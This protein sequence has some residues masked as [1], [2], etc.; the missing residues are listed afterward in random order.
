MARSPNVFPLRQ[1]GAV[2][3]L[4]EG[5]DAGM[6]LLEARNTLLRP[7]GGCK[8]P[9][10]YDRL[11][12]IGSAQTVQAIYRAL[13]YTG[14]L[15]G[16][17]ADS[18]ARAAN[19]TC[20]ILIKRQGKNFLLFYSLTAPEAQACKGWFYLG[21]DDSYT[22]GAY[23]FT[24]GT[25]TYE[26][27]AV[28]LDPNAR[29]YGTR[30]F[31][32]MLL[33]NGV[34]DNVIVQIARTATPGKWRKAGSNAKPAAPTISLIQP[35]TSTNVQASWAVTGRAG[36]VV[37]TFTADATNFPGAAGN[38]KIRVRIVPG[39]ASLVSSLAGEGTTASP[40]YYTLNTGTAAIHSS[41]NAIVSYV[42]ADSRVLSILRASTASSNDAADTGSY[43]PTDL[44][45]GSGS[46]SSEGFTNSTRK[47]YA[48][49]WDPGTEGLGYEGISSD[50][51][52]EVIITAN[53]NNDL[54]VR[55]PVNPSA[56]GGRFPFIRLYM[57]VGESPNEE[58]LLVDPDAPV[59]NTSASCLV[60][61]PGAAT[62][63]DVFRDVLY[64]YTRRIN[65]T[66]NVTTNVLTSVGHGFTA[67]QRVYLNTAPQ[68]AGSLP[69]TTSG[70]PAIRSF[71]VCNPTANTFQLQANSISPVVDFTSAGTSVVVYELITAPFAVGDIVRFTGSSLPSGLVANTDYFVT[72]V[73]ET[74]GFTAFTV[75]ATAAGSSPAIGNT[76]LGVTAAISARGKVIG[77]NTPILS[78]AEGGAM[79]ADQNRPLPH[80]YHALVGTKLWRGGVT[81]Y[82]TRLY[83]SKA[84]ARDELVP[85]GTNLD[86][87]EEVQLNDTDPGSQDITAMHTD[88]TKL[89]LH[90]SGGLK[91][92]NTPNTDPTSQSDPPVLAGALNGNCL[93]PWEKNQLFYLGSDLRI[94]R[95]ADDN[96]YTKL[97][98]TSVDDATQQY[99]RDRV[100]LT[101]LGRN[102]HR[103]VMFA[104][105]TAKM[106]WYYL[107][108]K[109]GT[110]K[111]FVYDFLRE[112]ITGEFDFPKVYNLA[113]ME[114]SRPELVFSDEAGNLF[115]W[116]TSAQNDSGNAFPA[117]AAPTPHPTTD[118]IPVQYR[119]YGYVDYDHDG[120]GTPSRFYQA[121]D[122][123]IQT[124]FFDM[125]TPERRKA[126]QALTFRTVRN[127]RGFVEATLIG[128]GGDEVTFTYGDVGE[129]PRA[130]HRADLLLTD[131]AIAVRFRVVAAEQK[132][133]I[134][135]DIAA[136]WRGQGV[137]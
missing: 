50:A 114:S 93:A 125:G 22:S 104:D 99:L 54:F 110:L 5:T 20:A 123:I 25:P 134:L 131:S 71:V 91:I 97:S 17:G 121:S 46:G 52:N 13:P 7:P 116:D 48:R 128:L 24:A 89:H 3:S 87:F 65:V 111:G 32:A 126:L 106:L 36:G 9:P 84:A 67:G 23:D 40:Y 1:F 35:A 29:W 132:P 63:I 137:I 30:A 74:E 61:S 37:L 51:S 72:S 21:D 47:V 42:N 58:Y 124:G 83:P 10:K 26:V 39:A 133:W 120:D 57:Q 115:V 101:E 8:G 34:D 16:I 108:A 85:E 92:L 75:S 81:G 4:Q 90:I 119:G 45:S 107:P 129:V 53:A 112:G 41:N 43:G 56:E 136:L 33:G 100:D 76:P 117:T 19:K 14:Y 135:R 98:A 78:A 11:W 69:G 109:D 118:P 80:L 59:A 68:S 6:A 27:M 55:V 66:I 60:T 103:A 127:S 130:D 18:T 113:R 86:S 31:T 64:S 88:G 73:S 96:L 105:T 70:N 94:Y 62:N 44:A 82:P 28:G 122:T 49:Y 2:T 95:Q 77:T 38:G 12:Q 15:S 102:P 79:S